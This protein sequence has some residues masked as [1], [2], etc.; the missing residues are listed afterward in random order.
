[1][2]KRIECFVIA[3]LTIFCANAQQLQ[4]GDYKPGEG[5]NFI[6]SDGNY[7]V[8]FRGYAQALS[9]FRKFEKDD[10]YFN[11]FRARR[12]RIRLAGK[13]LRPGISYRLQLNMA[14]SL[15]G[16]GELNGM[17]LDAFV[18]YQVHK[19]VKITIGQRATPTDNLELT[20]ASN[21]LQLPERSR[22]TSAFASIREVGMFIDGN[23]NLPGRAVLKPSLVITN[24][25]GPNT[26]FTD[27]GGLKYGTRINFLPF[28][29]FR[30]FGQF[31]QVDMIREITPKLMIG[32]N[33]SYNRGMSSRRGR[34]SGAIIYLNQNQQESLPDYMKY[35]FDVLFKYQ[36]F[37]VV[38]EYLASKSFVPKDI[39]TRVRNNGTTSETFTDANGNQ[40]IENYINGRM[41]LGKGIN[42]QAGY[43]TK[44][45]YSFDA[46]F[47]K[48]VP[49]EFSFMNNTLYYNR[50]HFYTIGLS[51]YLN[52]DYSYKIQTSFV[53]ADAE[54]GSR[55]LDG[56]E[57]EANEWM[58]RVMF[59]VSF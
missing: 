59:Q 44:K 48:L 55:N 28:G 43:L 24:G 31:R 49:D 21:T 30:F 15:E 17:L 7:H 27:R 37:S 38:A 19:R 20:F 52:K 4:L 51:K 29:R 16:D 34:A 39:T 18:A 58:I 6:S 8:I 26:F 32:G 2:R 13:S 35:G 40:N 46:R 54:E 53:Y 57:Q 42:I 10:K 14:Q 41:M 36:G 56:I 33:L 5:I 25:E 47:T 50:N 23:F 12:V 11:R 45:L 3:L 1:M 9:E 22:L